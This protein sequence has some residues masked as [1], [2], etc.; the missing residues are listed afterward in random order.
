MSLTNLPKNKKAILLKRPKN[1]VTDDL[2]EIIDED[3]IEPNSGEL[4][5]RVDTIAVD[6]W[7]R[8]TFDV[9]SYHETSK[10]NQSIGALGLG[11]VLISKSE[12]FKE[13][14]IVS[15][16]MGAQTHITM[17]AAAFN[18]VNNNKIDPDLDSGLLGPTTG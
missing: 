7:I 4:L 18:K 13:G 17:N 2:F 14:D 11:E 1:E 6:A 10:I 16:P 5:V 8:T 9:G 12:K 15:G 3:C